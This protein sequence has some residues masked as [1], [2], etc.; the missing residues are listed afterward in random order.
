MCAHTTRVHRTAYMLCTKNAQLR[1]CNIPQY[2]PFHL[3]TRVL[4]ALEASW[5]NG[6][7]W[8]ENW[9]HSNTW[10]SLLLE[11]ITNKWLISYKMVYC[12]MARKPA[13]RCRW[14]NS[15]QINQ[16]IPHIRAHNRGMWTKI[17]ILFWCDHIRL[18][19]LHVLCCAH[20]GFELSVAWNTGRVFQP[21][22]SKKISVRTFVYCGVNRKS[23]NDSKKKKTVRC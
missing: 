22:Q 11:S 13:I 4:S 23:R 15:L 9:T 16:C 8:H 18:W 10:V 14:N 20:S 2:L 6:I 19:M 1:S 3:L 21:V 17:I 5:P 12:R 7:G